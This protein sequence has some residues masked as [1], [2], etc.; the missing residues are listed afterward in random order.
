[1]GFDRGQ[2]SRLKAASAKISRWYVHYYIYPIID[3]L[4]IFTEFACLDKEVFDPLWIS[5]LYPTGMDDEL[6]MILHPEGFL[7]NNLLAQTACSADCLASSLP[8]GSP[9]DSLYWCAGCQGSMFPMN[10]NV[11]AHVGGVQASV[12]ATEKLTFKLHRLGMAR[13]NSSDDVTKICHKR[14]ALQMKKSHYRYQLVNPDTADCQPFGSTTIRFE[15]GKEKPIVGEDFGYLIWRKPVVLYSL[16]PVIF[17]ALA[18]CFISNNS[19]AGDYTETVEKIQKQVADEK[20]QYQEMV[21]VATEETKKY[22]EF[23][24][25]IVDA[26]ENRAEFAETPK[27]VTNIVDEWIESYKKIKNSSDNIGKTKDGLYVFVSLSMPKTL[28]ATLDDIARKIGAKLVIIGLKNNSFKETFHHIKKIKEEGI[29]VDINPE[30]FE[31]FEVKQV[32]VFMAVHHNKYDKLTGNVSLKY[33]LEQFANAGDTAE[34]AQTYL[35]R[36][37]DAA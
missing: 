23:A 13:E 5:E 17:M 32:P 37:R 36:L 25:K 33:A 14:L 3:M 26:I 9:I 8:Q 19:M 16:I 10:G 18:T 35:R 30:I 1:M 4:N 21:D 22:K 6:S 12:N 11:N 15:A 29:K 34:L 28:L 2:G 27:T 7:F 31:R 24:R 20:P